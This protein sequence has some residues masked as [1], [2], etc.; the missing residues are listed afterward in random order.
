MTDELAS[1][2]ALIKEFFETRN[3]GYYLSLFRQCIYDRLRCIW[4]LLLT[5]VGIYTAI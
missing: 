2:I 3:E 5:I 1:E 4:T